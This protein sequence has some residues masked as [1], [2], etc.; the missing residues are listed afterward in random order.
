MEKYATRLDTIA[1]DIKVRRH[2]HHFAAPGL[3]GWLA[4]LPA[5]ERKLLGGFCPTVDESRCVGCGTCA[6]VC[7]VGNI[8]MEGKAHMGPNCTACLGCLHACP[9]QAVAVGKKTIT[10]EQQYRHPKMSLP[11]LEQR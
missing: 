10:R 6:A 5:V 7:P 2:G 11:D 9:K 8:T 1:A 3:A 4:G